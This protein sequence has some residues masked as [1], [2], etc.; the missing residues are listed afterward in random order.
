MVGAIKNN[1]LQLQKLVEIHW[2]SVEKGIV[3]TKKMTENFECF[4]NKRQYQFVTAYIIIF[5]IGIPWS[6]YQK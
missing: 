6:L 3:A 2:A 1:L 4:S 5:R